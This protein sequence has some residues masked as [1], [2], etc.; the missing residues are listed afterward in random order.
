MT[1]ASRLAKAANKNG[2]TATELAETTARKSL[3]GPRTA[4][5]EATGKTPLSI[6]VAGFTVPV[7]GREMNTGSLGW[8]IGGLRVGVDGKTGA[9]KSDWDRVGVPGVDVTIGAI[10]L[11]A[12]PRK[13]STGSIGF[14]WSGKLDVHV[15]EQTFSCQVGVNLTIPKSKEFPENFVVGSR[16]EVIVGIN[17]TLVNSKLLPRE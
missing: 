12:M 4:F 1:T 2:F 13:F 5:L 17:V 8:S 10:R 11:T 15:G 16:V 6:G 14:G 9:R 7:Y 3:A